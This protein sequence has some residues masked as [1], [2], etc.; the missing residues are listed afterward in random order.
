MWLGESGAREPDRTRIRIAVIADVHFDDAPPRDS[1]SCRTTIADVLLLRAVHRLN[2]MIR[3]D[4]TLLLGDLIDK[5]DIS[6]GKAHFEYLHTVVQQVVSPVIAIPG[7]HDGDPEMFYS[8]FGKPRETLDIKGVRFVTFVD[9]KEPGYN[10]RRTK[11][12]L[13]RMAAARCGFDG[14]IVSVQHVPLFP[15]GAADCPYNYTNAE[16]IIEAMRRHGIVLAI[17]GHYHDGM[18]LMRGEGTGFV[19][20][21]ALCKPPFRFLEIEMEGENIRVREHALRIPEKLGLIDT[22]VHTPFAYCSDNMDIAKTIE[23]A[24]EF[25]L[26][27]VAFCEHSGHLY[28]DQETYSKGLPFVHGIDC[29]AG[30][31]PRVDAYFAA[32]AEAGCP[33]DSM[34]LETDCDYRGRLLIRPEDSPRFSYLTG[35]V[36]SLQ[37]L[38]RPDPD[39]QA[40]ANEYLF[41][42]ERF[43][44]TGIK[45][46]AHPFRV[47]RRAN[48]AV[49]VSLF[50]P[51]VRLLREH[52]IAAEIN[53]HT[54][55]PIA[56]FVRRCIESGVK[57]TFGS[58]AHSLYEIGEFTPHLAVIQAAGYDGDL[59]DILIDPRKKNT[60]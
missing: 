48:T 36:H 15:P 57:L 46:L 20:A 6:P 13:D 60:F 26:A 45:V 56:E 54:N 40:A 4:V 8:F 21:P 3:P 47:F 50:E 30:A 18:E 41:L 5:G 43:L 17:S 31:R 52:G 7:N 16:A 44:R 23:L 28:F 37:A 11:E 19:A 39:M 14:P 24:E 2:R 25:G 27:G 38:N 53:L 34:G 10:A 33:P 59:K 32:L 35:A 51:T 42:L 1:S 55:V 9:L 12:D 22:H 58:D 29:P 49:P